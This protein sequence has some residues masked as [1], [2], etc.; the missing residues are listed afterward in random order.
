MDTNS[1]IKFTM[2]II[3]DG[4]RSKAE[5]T[6]NARFTEK[7]GKYILYFDEKLED[8]PEITKCR[9][10]IED[11]ILRLRRT[12][13][14]VI[15]QTHIKAQKTSGYIKTPFGLMETEVK[16]NRF[17]FV[18]NSDGEYRLDLKY[19][20]YIDNEKAGNYVLKIIVDARPVKSL[21]D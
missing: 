14:I 11:N 1:K 9:F 16:T 6:T 2:T 3:Q 4:D 12:G 10:E 21:R 17:T 20:L 8:D 18:E 7:D 15:E 19:D 13:Q 5:Y